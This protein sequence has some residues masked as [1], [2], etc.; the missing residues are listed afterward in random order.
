MNT[1]LDRPIREKTKKTGDGITYINIWIYGKT[2]VG[3]ALS[4][5]YESPFLHPY[6]GQFNSMEGFWYYI[7]TREKD[8]RLRILAAAEAK[9]LG[10]TLTRYYVKNFHEIINAANF[11]RIEQNEK[12]KK[13]LME[14]TLPFEYYYLFG[15]GSVL[16]RPKGHEWLIEGFEEIRTMFREGRRPAEIDYSQ[17]LKRD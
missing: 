7:K 1:V 4:H 2:E 8:D 17:F 5:F 11:Y 3:R 6:F 10:K 16:I 9:A 14:S 15:P 12:I 13:L